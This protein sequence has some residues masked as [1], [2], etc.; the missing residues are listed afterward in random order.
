MSEIKQDKNKSIDDALKEINKKYGNDSIIRMDKDG[1]EKIRIDRVPSGSYLLDNVLG[2]GLP[3]G[4]I[5][6]LYGGESSGKS[7][8]SLFVV[9][10][11]QKLG[12]KAVWIDM[13]CID[14]NSELFN[15]LSGEIKTIEDVC[16]YIKNGNDFHVLSYDNKNKKSVISRV[17]GG[18]KMG[19]KRNGLKI[20]TRGGSEIITTEDHFILTYSGWKE[21]RDIK[22]G[23][24]ILK[25][26]KVNFFGKT[27]CIKKAKLLGYMLGDGCLSEKHCLSFSG[28]D[29]DVISDFNGVV[30][31]F[32]GMLLQ[33]KNNKASYRLVESMGSGGNKKTTKIKKI[34]IEWNLIGKKS[35]KKFIPP[36][37]FTMWNKNSIASLIKSLWLTDGTVFKN[38]THRMS[39]SYTTTSELLAKQIQH[40]LLRFGIVSLIS[41]HK[42][43]RKKKY[44]NTYNIAINGFTNIRLF[45]DHIGLIGYKQ[46][47]LLN[48][49]KN[50]K[51]YQPCRYELLPGYSNI[52]YRNKKLYI[53][54]GDCYYDEV[55]SIKKKKD[56]IPYDIEVENT[57]NFFANNILVHNCAFDKDYSSNIG[58]N[59]NDLIISRPD[60]GEEALDTIDSMARSNAVD[61]IIV[62]SV[63][64]MVPEKELA[65]EIIDEPMA[66]MARMMSK[67]MRMITGNISKSKTIVI[68]INQTR[69]K[70]GVFY[71]KKTTT[72]GGRALKFFSSIRLEVF[73]SKNINIRPSDTKSEV[74][75]NLMK[76][77]ATKNKVAPPFRSCEIELL[78]QHGIDLEA[79]LFDYAVSN[80]TIKK[81]ANT[82]SFGEEKLGVGK[83][84]CKKYL[85]DHKETKDKI[86]KALKK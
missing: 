24:F 41:K 16:E 15:P 23:D 46:K 75:G 9:A 60:T 77:S 72:P 63:S 1:M 67:G 74:I 69:D 35:D 58:V 66:R 42:D 37:V 80:S 48:L 55:V 49:I 83:E 34:F 29:K 3:R 54:S 18:R 70:I 45:I 25:P 43:S 4:R 84:V 32:N 82:Y 86:V 5:I 31:Y 26:K 7:T 85:K 71:G 51:Q 38:T 79:D 61:L 22:N 65:G 78:Y 12:G 27:Q 10:Q 56:I 47:R 76:I 57:H 28:I 17:V 14:R 50:M 36:E 19:D 44:L 39:M 33:E 2:G 30:K 13:E 6:E 62:D 11:I 64:A 81:D 73:K 52:K 20:R 8:L 40:L 21:S 68:F 59:V 53:N